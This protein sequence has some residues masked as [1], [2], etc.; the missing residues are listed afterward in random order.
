MAIHAPTSTACPRAL[1]GVAAGTIYHFTALAAVFLSDVDEPFAG[2]FTVWPGSHRALAALL[3]DERRA[4]QRSRGRTCPF[5]RC[6]CPSR[7]AS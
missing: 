3:R 6:R 7:R 1:N 2:N 4:R 5:R